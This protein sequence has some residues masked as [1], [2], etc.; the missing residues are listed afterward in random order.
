MNNL[1]QVIGSLKNLTKSEKSIA[2]FIMKN[3]IEVIRQNLTQL[4]QMT[5]TSNSAI[6]RF[7]QKLGYQGFSEF[8]F[9]MSRYILSGA[10]TGIEASHPIGAA[11]QVDRIVEKYI[12][13][14]NKMVSEINLQQLEDLVK[15]ICKARRI[16]I[17]GYNRT[18][19][20]AQQFAFRL[21]KLGIASHPIID[22]VVMSD[23][24][25]IMTKDDLTIICSITGANMYE[26]VCNQLCNSDSG[27]ILLTMNPQTPLKKYAT[28]PILLPR[29]SRSGDMSFLDD[30]A[31]FFIYIEILISEVATFLSAD[32]K[33]GTAFN[34]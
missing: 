28:N 27:L 25:N 4:A 2:E 11:K 18:G 32:E 14:L 34:T 31:I 1:L 10:D 6:I 15:N 19:L 22:P 26:D 3:P 23:Y 13:Y 5:H 8:K 9:D 12:Q 20:S 30:Q 33:N 29:I 17:M 16:I 21:A 24:S 7:C